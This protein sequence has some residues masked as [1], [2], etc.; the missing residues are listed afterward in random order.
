MHID[1]TRA[2]IA[3]LEEE[4]RQYSVIF[5]R[6]QIDRDPQAIEDL[7]V[8]VPFLRQLHE[9]LRH[10]NFALSVAMKSRIEVLA[11]QM[12]AVGEDNPAYWPLCDEHG[13]LEAELTDVKRAS[14]RWIRR[15]HPPE[16]HLDD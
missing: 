11:R 5:A 12:A 13:Q 3:E 6:A 10:Q 7:P 2:A 16:R 9:A 4:E 8:I 15:D 1:R 14:F